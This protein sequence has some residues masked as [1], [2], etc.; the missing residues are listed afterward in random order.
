MNEVNLETKLLEQ[1]WTFWFTELTV[2]QA[3]MLNKKLFPKNIGVGLSKAF[4][5][6][7]AKTPEEAEKEYNKRFPLRD[8]KAIIREDGRIAI[9]GKGEFPDKKIMDHMVGFIDYS[10][11]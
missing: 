5:Y 1:G 8:I 6:E 7:V 3:D 10:L 4:K 2:E 11:K 9:Y